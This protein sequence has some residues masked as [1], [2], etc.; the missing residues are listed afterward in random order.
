MTEFMTWIAQQDPMWALMLFPLLVGS[1]AFSCWR[2]HRKLMKKEADPRL[3]S[4]PEYKHLNR[5]RFKEL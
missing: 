1:I 5:K 2:D 4:E 3:M